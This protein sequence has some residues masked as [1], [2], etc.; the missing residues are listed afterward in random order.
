M[1]STESEQREV[2]SLRDFIQTMAWYDESFLPFATEHLS[3]N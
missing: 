2:E 1:V 3:S